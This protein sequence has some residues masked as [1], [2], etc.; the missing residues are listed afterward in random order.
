MK[1]PIYYAL[2][3]NRISLHTIL[4][5]YNVLFPQVLENC[6]NKSFFFPNEKP[7]NVDVQ[8]LPPPAVLHLYVKASL[9]LEN[10][11]GLCNQLEMF[12]SPIEPFLQFLEHFYL[13]DSQIFDIFVKKELVVYSEHSEVPIQEFSEILKGV[14]TK[15]FNILTGAAVYDDI[16]SIADHLG[17]GIEKITRETEIITDYKEFKSIPVHDT[18]Q[19]FSNVFVLHQIAEYIGAMWDFCVEFDLQQCLKDDRV[20]KLKAIVQAK[21]SWQKKSIRKLSEIVQEIQKLLKIKPGNDFKELS[22]LKL[23][24]PLYTDTKDLRDFLTENNFR[25][26]GK[27]RFLELFDLVTQTR[28]HDEYN[29]EVLN[30]LYAVYYVLVPLNKPDLS[31]QELID[32]VSKLDSAQC[33]AQLK[34]VKSNIDLIRM[35]FSK[36]EVRF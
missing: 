13:K 17:K 1:I 19:S 36:A 10:I 20:K 23:F 26:K 2:L 15:I 6:I 29:A 31:F 21:E 9:T 34:T 12:L 5:T 14:K 35:W 28:Q 16:S 22:F 25:G 30:P 27:D 8:H 24:R 11:A 7:Q 18:V 33:L 32:E 3:F 4:G